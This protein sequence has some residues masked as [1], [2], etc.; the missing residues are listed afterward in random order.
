MGHGAAG[1]ESPGGVV[2]VAGRQSRGHGSRADR[3]GKAGSGDQEDKSGGGG[4][5]RNGPREGVTCP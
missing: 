5:A 4:R 3:S 2:F 1:Q